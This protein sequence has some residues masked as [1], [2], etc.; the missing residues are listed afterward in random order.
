MKI[1]WCFWGISFSIMR[2]RWYLIHAGEQLTAILQRSDY[3]PTIINKK[4]CDISVDMCQAHVVSSYQG[5]NFEKLLKCNIMLQRTWL[6][7][8]LLKITMYFLTFEAVCNEARNTMNI[9]QGN[10]FINTRPQSFI[11]KELFSFS[12]WTLHNPASMGISDLKSDQLI[13]LRLT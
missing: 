1:L 4:V 12:R 10:F 3:Q 9:M 2:N 13:T 7:S 8:L 6:F 5:N 11:W